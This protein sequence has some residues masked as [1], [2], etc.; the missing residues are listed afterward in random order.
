MIGDD[1]L[2]IIIAGGGTAGH[3]NPGIAI[4]K[5]ILKNH[6]DAQILF[7][8]TE[9]GLEKELVP[10]EGFELRFI[11]VKGFKRKMS[12]DTLVS[13][14]E[15]IKGMYQTRKIINEYKPDIVIGTGGYVCGPVLINASF[16]GI[17]T[18]IHEQNVYPGVTNR[19]LSRF[20]DVV[21]VSFEESKK[22]IKSKNVYVTGNPVR[23]EILNS[24]RIASRK[25]LGIDNNEKLLVVFGGSI[26]AEKINRI[27][28]DYIKSAVPENVKLIFG[29]GA[30]QYN[31]VSNSLQNV[32]YDKTKINILP[33]IDNMG[34]VMAAADL[35]VCRAGAIT[36]SEITV[37]G[38]PAILIPSPNVTHNHQEYNARALEKVGAAKVITEKDLSEIDFG[39]LVNDILLDDKTLFKMGQRSRSIGRKDATE[40]IIDI[41]TKTVT[42]KNK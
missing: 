12:F 15:L 22:Y 38:V 17:P 32:K 36:L 41:I 7:V 10:K 25:N 2:K 18:I 27:L 37:I 16:M 35:M 4:A 24:N 3:I 42:L 20:V 11:S 21:M 28:V 34:D 13:V 6:P 26:G 29:T 14:K 23:Y 9:K 40:K 31:D 30:K 5:Q 39:C 8:G 1:Y 19:I 33:Y